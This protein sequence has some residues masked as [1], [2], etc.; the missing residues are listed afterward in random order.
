MN[1]GRR[2]DHSLTPTMR[3]DG[4]ATDWSV[5]CW[6]SATGSALFVNVQHAASDND[7]AFIAPCRPR[8]LP[9]TYHLAGELGRHGQAAPS[10]SKLAGQTRSKS[11]VIQQFL[12]GPRWSLD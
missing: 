8:S 7:A 11:E 4:D 6:P 2:N 12:S 1:C 10:A 9:A 5:V 3:G